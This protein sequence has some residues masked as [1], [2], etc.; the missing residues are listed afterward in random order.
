MNMWITAMLS[1]SWQGSA[2]A[3]DE[4]HT[5]TGK[6]A[7]VSRTKTTSLENQA[8][9]VTCGVQSHRA[10]WVL[11]LHMRSETKQ[12]AGRE[13]LETLWIPALQVGVLGK[14]H[15]HSPGLTLSVC[16]CSQ[17]VGERRPGPKRERSRILSDVCGSPR[18]DAPGGLVHSG[19]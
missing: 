8:V 9:R 12:L 6:A 19:I 15:T 18:C 13:A 10:W 2:R 11:S 16:W 1:C 4:Q 17:H 7:T 5:H 3:C 14:S